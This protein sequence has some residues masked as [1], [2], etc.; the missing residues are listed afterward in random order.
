M[1]EELRKLI[2]L[3]E[4]RAER[5]RLRA[6]AFAGDGYP[7]DDTL[8]LQAVQCDRCAQELKDILDNE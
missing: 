5:Y 2:E 4:N 8:T 6:G 1:E 3:W 7:D